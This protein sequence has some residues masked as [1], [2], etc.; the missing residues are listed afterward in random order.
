M[1]MESQRSLGIWGNTPAKTH[2]N[3]D[4][5]KLKTGPQLKETVQEVEDNVSET[6]I[7]ILREMRYEILYQQMETECY[8]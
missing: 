3:R 1:L 4:T 5:N 6:I 7:N 8:L 2:K